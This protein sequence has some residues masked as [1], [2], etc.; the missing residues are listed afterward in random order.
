MSTFNL[1]ARL[2]YLPTF[3]GT[4]KIELVPTLEN[5]VSK[6]IK[7]NAI[8]QTADVQAGEELA[9][10]FYNVNTKNYYSRTNNGNPVDHWIQFAPE[11]Y[12]IEEAYFYTSKFRLLP[13]RYA[14]LISQYQQPLETPFVKITYS[15]ATNTSWGNSIN[16]G[17]TVVLPN[18]VD[19]NST[20]KQACTK[21]DSVF[22]TFHPHEQYK[23]I[24]MQPY[25]KDFKLTTEESGNQTYPGGGRT[26]M[27]TWNDES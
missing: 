5:M 4:W 12:V 9:F 7:Y 13:D 14:F 23:A 11:H 3:F 10:Q 16:A 17:G 27:R 1:L 2:R 15:K 20:T 21:I 25:I 24:C 19:M 6:V 18:E 22:I 26:T 8:L